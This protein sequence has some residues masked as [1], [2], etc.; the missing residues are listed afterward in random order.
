MT[1]SPY[2]GWPLL[3]RAQC[4]NVDV[5][6]GVLPVHPRL[7]VIFQD[8]ATRY[9]ETVEPLV[10]PG[11]WGYA[12]PDRFIGS[13]RVPSKHWAGLAIDLDAPQHPQGV[14]VH[15]TFTTRELEAIA[16]LEARYGGVIGWG[17]RWS[18]SSVDGMHWELATGATGAQVDDLTHA[19]LGT[20]P[21]SPSVPL[22]S[23]PAPTPAGPPAG[24]WT[25]PDLTG[26]SLDLRGEQGH[27]GLRVQRLQ[28]GLLKSYP[29][30]ARG[31]LG[32]AG[33]DGWWG[34]RTTGVLRTFAVNS[35]VRSAD[36]RNIG[37]QL[38]RKLYLAGIRP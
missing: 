15:I 18:G 32:P 22:P 31:G 11:C 28:A 16:A 7:A 5:P 2:A 30:Y 12:G 1:A 14:P 35:G 10:W 13:S 20:P 38:A 9:H 25:G 23:P 26:T 27:N 36:G 29:R 3:T 33:A 24:G 21:P 17:G 4:V 37:P 8:L 34:E 19:I 6:G